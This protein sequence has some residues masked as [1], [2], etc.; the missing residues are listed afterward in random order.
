MEQTKKTLI[1]A[2]VAVALAV[3]A[4]LAA[5]SRITPEAF[6]D[7]GEAFF[8]AFTDPN[9]AMSLEIVSFDKETGTARPFKVHFKDGLWTI[10]SHYDYPAD[11]RDRLAKTAASIIDLKKDDYRTDS[12]ADFD[13]LGVVDPLDETNPSLTGRGTRVTVRGQNDVVLADLIVGRDVPGRPGMKYVRLPDQKRVYAVRSDVDLSG[14]FADWIKTDLLEVTRSKINRVEINDYSIDEQTR[15]IK[16]RD[17]MILTRKEDGT[18]SINNLAA[19]RAL[20]TVAVK[21]LLN[22]LD[23]LS[24]VG[25]RPKPEGLSQSLMASNSAPIS[26]NDIMSLQSKGFYISRDGQLLSN[27]GEVRAYTDDGVVYTLRFGEVLFGGGEDVDSDASGK[28]GNGKEQ[29][30]RYLFIST[31]FNGGMFPEPARPANEEFRNKADS[32]LT[33]ADRRN[34]EI[35]SRHDQWKNKVDRGRKQTEQL[36]A[37]FANWYYVISANSFDKLHLSRKD[38]TMAH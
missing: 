25:V 30:N 9:S 10:P 28:T 15:S 8:P 7:Q 26:Q 37:R 38:L 13:T 2:G 5:P 33:D 36:N 29:E 35:G 18:W 24:I 22:A 31:D 23:S 11:A 14:R 19:H 16:Q 6:L 3:I 17:K 4:W 27:E 1:Y 20:D 32:L 34:K 21:N 12:P